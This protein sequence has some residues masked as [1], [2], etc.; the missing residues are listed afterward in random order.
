MIRLAILAGP[1][2]RT[3]W[4]VATLLLSA[5]LGLIYLWQSGLD[6]YHD[7]LAVYGYGLLPAHLWGLRIP[8]A[9]LAVV[10]PVATL[11]TAQFLHGGIGHLLGNVAAL[12]LV[13]PAT[14]A[15]VGRLRF[16]AVYVVAGGLG[17]LVEAA[18]TPASI[19]PIIGA[20]AAV[21]GVIG[22]LARRNPRARVRLPWIGRKGPYLASIPVLPLIATW[23][24]VQTAGIAFAADQ[25]VAF[26]AH[27]AGFV[28]GMILAGGGRPRLR[29]IT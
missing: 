17:L 5:S 18:A 10:P 4:P 22:A 16:L 25:P 12:I 14:E 26:L 13:G 28:A 27:G 21:A 3:G 15:A 19:V 23:L 1:P 7:S 29:S 8:P 11:V 9:H 2:V 24:M 6:G 20:S